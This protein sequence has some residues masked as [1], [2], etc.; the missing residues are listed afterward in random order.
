[1]KKSLQI[2]LILF[3]L[4]LVFV[5]FLTTINLRPSGTV[6]VQVLALND[7]HGSLLPPEEFARRGIKVDAGGVEYL[8]THLD[9]LR[10]LN[11]NTILVSAGD[12]IGLSPQPSALFRDE[13]AIE[14]FNLI[15]VELSAVGNHDL[16]NGID[17]LLRMQD[18]DCH[19]LDGCLDGDGFE[20][21]RFHF[22]AANMTWKKDDS[23]VFPAYE[24]RKFDGVPI[25]FIGIAL[26]RT[27]A[28]IAADLSELSFM[29]E[30]ETVNALVPEIKRQGVETIVVLLHE[31]GSQ[32]PRSSHY[33]K[34]I[35][36][37]GRV[38]DIV[39]KLND[40]VD[41]VLSGHEEF[42]YNCLINHKIVTNAYSFGRLI[43]KVDLTI[44]RRSR[45]VVTMAAEN[46]IVTR[47]VPKDRR[48]TA[49]ID[50]YVFL[51]ALLDIR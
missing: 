7:F 5:L 45:D 28:T 37:T 39:N 16:E 25:A 41:V 50:K 38:V 9:Y 34:C 32:M 35:G 46:L 44:D 22:L 14:A 36:I 20:G 2:S 24:I 4:V 49:L 1:M 47:D 27:P 17:E 3:L 12:V 21:A 10:T 30:A 51:A 6:E 11:P 26:E 33:N 29:D 42:P 13:P 43:T 40:D 8:A 15:G 48:L 23:L 18:G 31:G 19:P